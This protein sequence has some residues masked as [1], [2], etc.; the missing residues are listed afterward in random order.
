MCHWRRRSCGGRRRREIEGVIIVDRACVTPAAGWDRPVLPVLRPTAQYRAGGPRPQRRRSK[1]KKRAARHAS[2]FN[3]ATAALSACSWLKSKR[4]PD[5]ADLR[6][7]SPCSAC[8]L[9]AAVHSGSNSGRAA[10]RDLRQHDGRSSL[11][12]VGGARLR[13]NTGDSMIAQLVV[14]REKQAKGGDVC[15]GEESQPTAEK[16][17]LQT[18]GRNTQNGKYRE[19]VPRLEIANSIVIRTGK[20]CY[21]VKFKNK[22][23]IAFLSELYELVG[24]KLSWSVERQVNQLNI[25][26]F[27]TGVCCASASCWRR[28]AITTS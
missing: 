16:W 24:R 26:P 9:A 4:S 3:L 7:T 1:T 25:E 20:T 14:F 18:Q 10:P 2:A 11:R 15:V 28:K 6:P 19:Q 8:Y 23:T 22:R 12:S 5:S 27:Y 21:G 17:P 13:D